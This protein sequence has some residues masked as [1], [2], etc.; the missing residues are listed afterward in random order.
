MSVAHGLSQRY[1]SVGVHCHSGFPFIES[2]F[3][4]GVPEKRDS[5]GSC[6]RGGIKPLGVGSGGVGLMASAF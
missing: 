1:G 5:M 2:G 3:R 4:Y 6:Q